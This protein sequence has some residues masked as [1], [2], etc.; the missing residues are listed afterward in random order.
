MAVLI[1][2]VSVVVRRDA[3]E[4]KIAGGW[5]SFSAA[6][7]TAQFCYDNEIARVGFMAEAD[8]ETF[9]SHL[10]ALGLVVAAPTTDTDVCVVEQLGRSGAPATW[11]AVSRL[12]TPEIGGEVAVA[13]LKGTSETRVVMPGGWKFEGSP[14]QKPLEFSRADDPRLKFL[15]SEGN[16]DVY[17]DSAQAREVYA[18]RPYGNRP[19]T[20]PALTEAQRNE[21]N[22]LWEQVRAISDELKLYS[23]VPPSTRS[24]RCR[25]HLR[26]PGFGPTSLWHTCLPAM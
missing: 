5:S 26:T 8:A 15:R 25:W 23:L 6:V 2:A 20:A 9:L 24:R 4:S 18:A 22:R 21:H 11:L 16:V 3:I 19:D 7:P 12:S 13:F 1:E 17:W 10:R 14:S